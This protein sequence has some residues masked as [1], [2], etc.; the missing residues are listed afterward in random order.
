MHPIAR[1]AISSLTPILDLTRRFYAEDGP[2]AA[3]G[4]DVRPAQVEMSMQFA[5]LLDGP[6]GTLGVVEAPCGTGKGMA[7]LVPGLLL[8]LRRTAQWWARPVWEEGAEDQPSNVRP[9][10]PRSGDCPQKLLVTTAGIALQAQFVSKDIPALGRL[11]GVP[12]RATLLKSKSNYLCRAKLEELDG[13]EDPEVLRLM[14]WDGDGDRESVTWDVSEVW[15]KVSATGDECTGKSCPHYHGAET[16]PLCHWRAAVQ[17]WPEAHIIVTNHHYAILAR[18]LPIFAAA[19]DEAHE[20][21]GAIRTAL[22]RRLHPSAWMA[23]AKRAAW[24]LRAPVEDKIRPLA[25]YVENVLADHLAAVLDGEDAPVALRPGWPIGAVRGL[26][27]CHEVWTRLRRRLETKAAGEGCEFV[28]GRCVAG[29]GVHEDVKTMKRIA[30]VV[31]RATELGRQLAALALARA[32]PSWDSAGVPWVIWAQRDP[33]SRR[34]VVAFVPVDV[35]PAL[36]AF[37]SLSGRMLLTSATLPAFDSLRLTL[38]IG[39]RSEPNEAEPWPAE[40]SEYEPDDTGEDDGEIEG[41]TVPA[42]RD[43]LPLPVFERRLP[44]PFPLSQMGRMVV[45]RG[46]LPKE[47]AWKAWAAERVVEA[48]QVAGGGTLVLASS[49]GQMRAYAVALRAVGAWSVRCQGETGRGELRAWFRDDIDGV[50]VATRSFFQGLDVPGNACRCVVIDRIPFAAPDD[51][52]EK[53]V[54]A[55]LARRAGGGSPWRLRSVPQAAMVLEQGVGRLIRCKTDRGTVVLLDRRI[56]LPGPEWAQIRAA[57]P[58]F[59]IVESL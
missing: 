22:E 16:A 40:W 33:E 17:D 30:G 29:R 3:A 32:H 10:T 55:L 36:S 26:L 24:V 21:E 35:A 12:I 13:T 51:P 46:P 45:P 57:L 5:A 54:G 7:Y 52:V 53:A 1:D 27:R 43:L 37:A 23:L 20:M 41:L 9:A 15:P 8:A 49:A 31:N 4:L 25:E 34:P 39:V 38:G 47:T 6:R 2:L 58:P 19:V 42:S 56:L 44:S 50:L 14:A 18:G 28:E 59:P 11:L 48:V